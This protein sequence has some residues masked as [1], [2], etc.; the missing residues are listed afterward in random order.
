MGYFED[1]L[2]DNN[3]TYI[4]YLSSEHWRDLRRRKSKTE[5]VACGVD[6]N[7]ELHHKT[8]KR[9]GA[10][11]LT[12][13]VW[14]CGDCHEKVHLYFKEHRVSLWE[15]SDKV[16]KARKTKKLLPRKDRHKNGIHKSWGKNPDNRLS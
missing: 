9:I 2:N 16:I 7:L 1:Y 6:K 3:I 13:V 15:A 10:E 14:L 11:K 4:E 12:D 5:C 8:Y